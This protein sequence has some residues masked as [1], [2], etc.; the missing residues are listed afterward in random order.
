[1]TQDEFTKLLT[2]E[3]LAALNTL[4]VSQRDGFHIMYAAEV[5]KLVDAHA[6]LTI[7]ANDVKVDLEGKLLKAKEESDDKLE[8]AAKA[9]AEQ[10]AAYDTATK[11]VD[12]LKRQ[13]EITLNDFTKVQEHLTKETAAKEDLKKSLDESTQSATKLNERMARLLQEIPFNPRWMAIG[14]F[15]ARVKNEMFTLGKDALSDEATK[16]ILGLLVAKETANA[17]VNLDSPNLV[18]ALAYLVGRGRL[19]EERAKEITQDCTRE[20][21]YAES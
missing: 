9:L 3:Q 19:T 14:P 5:G 12:E 8:V 16:N 6:E 18:G 21:A 2:P 15:L 1:M 11:R 4:L 7:I 20:E 13:I 17:P 10:V